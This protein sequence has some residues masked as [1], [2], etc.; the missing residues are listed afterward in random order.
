MDT[1]GILALMQTTADA[2]VRPRFRSLSDGEVDE[3]APGDYVTIADKE[4]EEMLTRLLSDAFPG[5]AVIGEEAVFTDP[6]LLKGLA[7]LEHAFV[8]DPI[9]GTGNFVRGDSRYGMILAELKGGVTTR[10]WIWQP[11]T[12]RAYV[13]ERGAGARVNGEPIVRDVD[14]RLPLGATSKK[15]LIGYT[16]EGRLSPVVR[17]NFACAFDYPAVLEGDIDFMTYTSIHPWDHLAGSLMLTETGGVSRTFDGISY[18]VLSRGRGL[19]I[20][21]DTLSWMTAQQCWPVG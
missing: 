18:T 17:S 21:G 3:K 5:A 1:D 20:A 4:S 11:E 12:G 15:H 8:I 13:A 6:G 2:V 16:A 10:G 7:N 19:L 14:R 9:D